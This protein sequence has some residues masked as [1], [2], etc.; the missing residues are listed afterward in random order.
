MTALARCSERSCP[1][2]YRSGPDRP[3]PLH[4]GDGGDT[5]AARMAAYGA[6][7]QAAPGCT[8]SDADGVGDDG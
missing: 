6:V 1:V 4:A 3:C 5:L 7:L 8:L 2:R